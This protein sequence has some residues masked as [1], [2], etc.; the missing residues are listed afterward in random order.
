MFGGGGSVNPFSRHFQSGRELRFHH[1]ALYELLRDY[2]L[3]DTTTVSFRA[4]RGISSWTR[5]LGAPASG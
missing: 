4:K 3:L 5:S 2:Y 1:R